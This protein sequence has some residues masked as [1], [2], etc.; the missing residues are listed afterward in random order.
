MPWFQSYTG[1]AIDL[2]HP[3]PDVVD[4]EDIAHSLSL[5][6]RFIGHCKEFYSVAEHSVNVSILTA[7]NCVRDGIMTHRLAD[8]ILAGLLHDAAEAYIGDIMTPIKQVVTNF[9]ARHNKNEILGG[10]QGYYEVPIDALKMLEWDWLRV[11]GEKFGLGASLTDLPPSVKI[12][13][14]LMLENEVVMLLPNPLPGWKIAPGHGK[15][16][17]QRILGLINCLSPAQARLSYLNSFHSL[18]WQRNNI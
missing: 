9:H 14:R 4:I 10:N 15:G 3:T 16:D 13:D 2:D 5:Q 17:H 8:E 7:S 1:K 18:Q 6:C 11:I 12:S